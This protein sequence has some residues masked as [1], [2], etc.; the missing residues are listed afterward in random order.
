[1]D[2]AISLRLRQMAEEDY[3]AFSQKLLPGVP[4]LLGVRLPKLRAFARELAKGDAAGYLKDPPSDSFEA[5]M[6]EGMVIGCLKAEP[7]EILAYAA[8][9]VPKID[10]WSVNDSFCAGLAVAKRRPELVWDFLQP[11]L[12]AEEEFPLRFALVMLLDYY[13]LPDYIDRVLRHLEGINTTA[14]YAQMAQAW[15]LSICYLRFPEKTLPL[16]QGQALNRDTRRKSI[17]K[18]LESRRLHPEQRERL[19]ALRSHL[20]DVP[21]KETGPTI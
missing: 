17:Q 5:V 10:N 14:Y 7:E 12:Q 15:A 20:A 9:F 6:L 11:Y 16:L 1:M 13:I 4:N 3:R 18:I 2:E 21:S 8:R 19:L